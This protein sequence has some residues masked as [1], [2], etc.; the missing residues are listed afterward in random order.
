MLDRPGRG[1]GGGEGDRGFVYT[2]PRLPG[3]RFLHLQGKLT[4]QSSRLIS[5]SQLSLKTEKREGEYKGIF[6][7]RSFPLQLKLPERLSPGGSHF[8]TLCEYS[9]QSPTRHLLRCPREAPGF[10]SL[11][12]AGCSP[13]PPAAGQPRLLGV[14]ADVNKTQESESHRT[15]GQGAHSARRVHT[16][17]APGAGSRGAQQARLT[18][19]DGLP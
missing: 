13:R 7:G 10:C 12:G 18:P 19:E 5:S 6:T 11:L 2:F 8:G 15:G 16:L 9:R 17:P 1:R 4:H 3:H 14:H